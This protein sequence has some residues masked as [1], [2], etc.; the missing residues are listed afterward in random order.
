MRLANIL[1]TTDTYRNLAN[2][3]VRDIPDDLFESTFL[4][5]LYVIMR[6]LDYDDYDDTIW[7]WWLNDV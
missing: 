6:I 7:L 1:T 2:N 5:T 3:N 4:L